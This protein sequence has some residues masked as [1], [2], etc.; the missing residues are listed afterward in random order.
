MADR[1][2]RAEYYRRYDGK[3]SIWGRYG[4]NA[5]SGKETVILC[6]YSFLQYST[7]SKKSFCV[8]VEINST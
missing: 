4:Q 7:L 3:L 5:E 1:K 2:I 6:S 8:F